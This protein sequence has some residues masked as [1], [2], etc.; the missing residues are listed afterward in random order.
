[1]LQVKELIASVADLCRAKRAW[2]MKSLGDLTF[3]ALPGAEEG[4]KLP[5]LLTRTGVA[6]R[7]EAY[8]NALVVSDSKGR[9]PKPPPMVSALPGFV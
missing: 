2:S 1:L 3:N 4:T 5:P 7:V 8:D 9:Y 6:S